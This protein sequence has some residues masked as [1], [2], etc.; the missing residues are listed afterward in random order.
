M[1]ALLAAVTAGVKVY[2]LGQPL[3]AAMPVSPNHPPFR[4]ALMRRHGDS[5]R[6]D[7]SSAANDLFTS[8]T[9]VGTHV[10]ALSHVSLDDHL[11]GG[12]SASEAQRGGRFASHGIEQMPPL[13]RRG[14]LLDIPRLKGVDCLEPEQA[15][16]EGDLEAAA[17]AQ[18]VEVRD[19]DVVL[20]R[21]G[22]PRHW[23]DP[24][25]FLG[26]EHGV[27][28]PDLS[29]AHWISAKGA[30]CT[31]AE[32]VAYEQILAGRGHAL[33]PVHVHLLVEQGI[34]IIEMLNL[35]ELA[36]DGVS[37]FTFVLAPLKIVGATGSPVRPLAVVSA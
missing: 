31:G 33:L 30:V 36:A 13:V 9:H 12:A 21:T 17:R 19:G 11:F 25:H 35:T 4:S 10:D 22:W 5:V 16:T 24:A 29:A 6:A 3:E 20:V 32:T 8:G 28:G 7:G 15:V 1:D 27:P 2:D 18:G 37:E 23:G 26:H 14:V 34:N